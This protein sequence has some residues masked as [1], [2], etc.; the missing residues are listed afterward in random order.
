MLTAEDRAAFQRDGF[1]LVRDVITPDQVTGLR[2]F[3]TRH[4]DQGTLA[5]GDTDRTR[6]D[7][8]CRH[9]EVRWLLTHE[10]LVAPLRGLLGDDFVYI[11]EATAHDSNFG[12]WHK[13]TTSQESR[14]HRFHWDDDFL[15]VQCALY[16]QE[17]GIHGGGVDVNVGSHRE[18]D[19]YLPG[20]DSCITMQAMTEGVDPRTGK[21]I[22]P[23]KSDWTTHPNNPMR[24]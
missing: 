15:M 4:F 18:P 24:K 8:Y 7:I 10:P 12:G 1:L 5:P 11:H 14:G 6:A 2:S 9:P 20:V 17:N 13:D 19:L 3:W 16:L 21:K 23:K 22:N